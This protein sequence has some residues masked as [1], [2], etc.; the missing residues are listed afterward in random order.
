MAGVLYIDFA[1]MCGY[2]GNMDIRARCEPNAPPIKN[3]INTLHELIFNEYDIYIFLANRNVF[4]NKCYYKRFKI[5]LLHTSI[6]E[7][8]KNIYSF[9]N[10]GL[11][12]HP[13]DIEEA[14]KMLDPNITITRAGC[15]DILEFIEEDGN[16]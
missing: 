3:N 8:S 4:L 13:E 10:N 11:L 15:L 7:V 5:L 9:L 2:V 1:N 6:N 16:I 12:L 14:V